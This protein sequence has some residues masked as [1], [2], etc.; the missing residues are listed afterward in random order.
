MDLMKFE[1]LTIQTLLF[2]SSYI[3]LW[4]ILGIKYYHIIGIHGFVL[5]NIILIILF[6]VLHKY[7]SYKKKKFIDRNIRVSSCENSTSINLEYLITYI[8]PF[9]QINVTNYRGFIALI[10]LF[11]FI[12][13]L[14][15]SS[16]LIYINPMLSI[17]GYNIFKVLD[18]K[19]KR[20]YMLITKKEKILIDDEI[21]G[22]ALY[23][24]IILEK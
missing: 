3:P 9:T 24:D 2:L 19:S 10:V 21:M 23:G 20:E 15:I 6:I 16:N 1:K 7:I 12:W 18:E 14:Y 4:V 17:M 13:W 11:I 8:I 22:C 5:L